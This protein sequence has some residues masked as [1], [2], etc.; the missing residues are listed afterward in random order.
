MKAEDWKMKAE[1]WEMKAEGLEMKAEK[2]QVCFYKFLYYIYIIL[3]LYTVYTTSHGM[4]MRN[5]IEDTSSMMRAGRETRAE[6]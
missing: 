3:M 2:P 1:G 6:G 5:G 4:A